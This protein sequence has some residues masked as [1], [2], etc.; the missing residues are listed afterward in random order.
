MNSNTFPL[1]V[2]VIAIAVSILSKFLQRFEDSKKIINQPSIFVGI[3]SYCDNL[4]LE[5]AQ[6]ILNSSKYRERIFIG[7]LEFVNDANETLEDEIPSLLRDRIVVFTVSKKIATS[8]RAARQL[9]FQKLYRSEDFIVFCRS[10]MFNNSWDENIINSLTREKCVFTTK[11]L[12]KNISSFPAIA[13]DGEII[14]KEMN[15]ITNKNIPILIF[16][17]DFF[18]CHNEAISFILSSS[19]EWN[20]SAELKNNNFN[21]ITSCL[22]AGTRSVHPKGVKK[23]ETEI[24]I[25]GKKYAHEI[26]FNIEEKTI[27]TAAKLGL[28]P[29]ASTKECIAK[30]GSVV[31]ARVEF[32]SIDSLKK[33]NTS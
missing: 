32:Q 26:G 8:Q 25:S 13:N 16:I 7:V 18:A 6:Q 4:W 14:I 11:I 2:V 9:C 28:L 5:N 3:I 21:L 29:N 22:S 19:N 1:F 17:A 31:A 23:G 33:Y 27:T 20:I 10:T 30:F 12:D 15:T 24:T